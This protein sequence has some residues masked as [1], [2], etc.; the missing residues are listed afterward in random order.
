MS[1]VVS[2]LGRVL[3]ARRG[4]QSTALVNQGTHVIT[5]VPPRPHRP[6]VVLD[7][8]EDE[9]FIAPGSWCEFVHTGHHRK[10]PRP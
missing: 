1:R 5:T 2:L 4:P 7:E 9:W 3:P 6:A 8:D 10:A